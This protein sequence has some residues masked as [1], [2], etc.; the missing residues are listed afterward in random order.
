MHTLK[1]K[2]NFKCQGCINATQPYLNQLE[3]IKNWKV[4]DKK[5]HKELIVEADENVN[6]EKVI[7]AVSQAGYTATEKKEGFLGKLMG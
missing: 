5:D 7:E 1:F 4:N 2:T 6:R 3:G